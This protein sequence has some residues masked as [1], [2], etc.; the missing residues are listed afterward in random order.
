MTLRADTGVG[1]S[2]SAHLGS[3]PAK[4]MQIGLTGESRALQLHGPF[5]LTTYR[6]FHDQ[7]APPPDTRTC[8]RTSAVDANPLRIHRVIPNDIHM[9][10]HRLIHRSLPT[11]EGTHAGSNRTHR[12]PFHVKQDSGTSVCCGGF[13]L[14]VSGSNNRLC[15]RP[16]PLDLDS[17]DRSSQAIKS[18]LQHQ[19]NRVLHHCD[20]QCFYISCTD[21]TAS[22]SRPFV[23]GARNAVR[24]YPWC[25]S[26][27]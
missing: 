6:V 5:T 14:R 16:E 12:A 25:R 20:Q 3:Q 27:A 8:R 7:L 23:T 26:V 15:F 21:P 18:V 13:R 4:S 1:R 9:V 17:G 2:R 22:T 19:T 11:S 24:D 10:I